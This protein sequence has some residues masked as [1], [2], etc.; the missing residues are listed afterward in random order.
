MTPVNRWITTGI[1]AVATLVCLSPQPSFSSNPEEVEAN[2]PVQDR[3]L[4][5]GMIYI[6]A[7]YVRMGQTGVTEPVHDVYLEAFLI[8]QFEVTNG[9]YK[10]FMDAGGYTTEEYWH[11][12]GWAYKQSLGFTTPFSWYSNL[13][14]GGGIPGNSEFPVNGVCWW[15]ADAYCRWAGVRL[16]SEA[17]WE[18]AAKGGCE[19]NGDPEA[20]DESDTQTYPWGEGLWENRANYIMSDDPYENNGWT[21]PVGYYNGSVYGTF[22][23]L[24]SP[25]PYGLY[26]VAGNVR[27]WTN[28]RRM[29]YPYDPD[30]GREDPPAHYDECCR[31]QRGGSFGSE[32]SLRSAYRDDASP[33]RRD[34]HF[35]FRVATS[36]VSAVHDDQAMAPTSILR[37]L[38]ISPNP[39]SDAIEVRFSLGQAVSMDLGIF[40]SGGRLVWQRAVEPWAAGTHVMSLESFGSQ[41]VSSG[42]YFLRIRGDGWKETK[43]F[44]MFR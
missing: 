2:A 19:I 28:S 30:D 11:P 18:K 33:Y 26:D 24:N 43:T 7:G 4:P 34:Q 35:G 44:V 21:T 3:D 10:E 6:P 25:S 42:V 39:A 16:P 40:D 9:E 22:H 17:E 32:P 37:G 23:T 31:V 27:D 20:C 41:A 1:L 5:E 8:G 14:H 13:Y 15:E 12:V 36:D 38:S 29:D